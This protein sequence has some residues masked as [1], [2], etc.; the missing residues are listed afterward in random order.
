ME[1]EK[2]LGAKIKKGI[3]NY[4]DTRSVGG[5][6]PTDQFNEWED[7]VARCKTHGI[8]VSYEGFFDMLKTTNRINKVLFPLAEKCGYDPVEFKN[9]AIDIMLASL[10]IVE[11]TDVFK[12]IEDIHEEVITKIDKKFKSQ[13]DTTV[14]HSGI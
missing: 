10:A 1:K 7:Y 6:I 12:R 8:S 14:E 3:D 9:E 5:H 2:T 11:T 13:L 4:F